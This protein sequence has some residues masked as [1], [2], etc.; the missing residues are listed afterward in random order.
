M[1]TELETRELGRAAAEM[2][3]GEKGFS[4]TRDGPLRDVWAQ[5]V[6]VGKAC[7]SGYE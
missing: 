4:T 7:P 6:A 3:P 5:G 1:R 2:S